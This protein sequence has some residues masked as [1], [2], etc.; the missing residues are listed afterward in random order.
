MPFFSSSKKSPAKPTT[1]SRLYQPLIKEDSIRILHLQPSK[2]FSS[3]ICCNL[4]YSNLSKFSGDLID[5]YT[6]LSYVWGDPRVSKPILVD[7]HVV[8]ATSNLESALRNLRDSS[9]VLKLWVDA[10]CINQTDST[11]K[12]SQVRLMGWIYKSA[13]HTIIYLGDATPES[14]GI[15]NLVESETSHSP[16]RSTYENPAIFKAYSKSILERQW[17]SRIWILQELV[18][19]RDPW[20]QCG[21]QKVRWNVLTKFDARIHST[22]RNG[23]PSVFQEMH[24]MRT[25][26]MRWDPA[27]SA[28]HRELRFWQEL[29][30]YLQSRRGK[31]VSNPVDMIYAHL[32]LSFPDITNR[33]APFKALPLPI[34]YHSTVAEVFA[35]SAAYWV[36]TEANFCGLVEEVDPSMRRHGLLSWTP[37]WT[38]NCLRP[39]PLTVEESQDIAHPRAVA[40]PF[41]ACKRMVGQD[42]RCTMLDTELLGTVIELGPIMNINRYSPQ[43]CKAAWQAFFPRI[44]IRSGKD[45]LEVLANRHWKKVDMVKHYLNF[46]GLWAP[47]KESRDRKIRSAA[48][49]LARASESDSPLGLRIELLYNFPEERKGAYHPFLVLMMLHMGCLGYGD[50]VEWNAK[51]ANGSLQ[52]PIDFDQRRFCVINSSGPF[53]WKTNVGLVPSF[54]KPGDVIRLIQKGPFRPSI[55]CVFRPSKSGDVIL[56]DRCLYQ[57][58]GRCFFRVDNPGGVEGFLQIRH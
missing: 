38:S 40:K 3:P 42:L 11:E 25:K 6:A 32:G 43:E 58:V 18:L 1:G 17:F 21:Q 30:N 24:M 39:W 56:D 36:K 27:P 15:M 2:K 57:L 37:D 41:P 28:A 5:S 54:T 10:V 53:G 50:F 14:K 9:R 34:N 31:G 26:F 45:D 47:L 44:P 19:S 12:E 48:E 33:L 4:E 13:D 55:A 22:I 23:R 52:S 8:Q 49:A 29:L 51:E 20:V 35:T 16:S 7:N 46:I